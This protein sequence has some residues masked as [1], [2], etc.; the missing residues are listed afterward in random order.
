MKLPKIFI[1]G[2]RLR[3]IF[4]FWATAWARRSCGSSAA[5]T[6]PASSAASRVDG[7]LRKRSSRVREGRRDPPVLVGDRLVANESARAALL[8]L[9]RARFRP[10]ACPPWP[11]SR[12]RRSQPCCASPCR[13]FLRTG[14]PGNRRPGGSGG[15]DLVVVDDVDALDE[16]P[17]VGRLAVGGVRLVR[18]SQLKTTSLAVNSPRPR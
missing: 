18:S 9:V 5:C 12:W 6:S 17:P 13:R 2:S 14:S 4:M 3:M 11:A 15:N 8:V 7:S 10:A 1:A 16:L